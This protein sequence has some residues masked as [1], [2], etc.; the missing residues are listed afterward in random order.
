MA[1]ENLAEM[2]EILGAYQM[3][4]RLGGG[5]CTWGTSDLPSLVHE[6]RANYSDAGLGGSDDASQVK[7]ENTFPPRRR[8]RLPLERLHSD[9]MR[10]PKIQTK[11]KNAILPTTL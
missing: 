10:T 2:A 11:P 8:Q 9:V 5:S 3:A 6:T 1:R 7:M 4:G